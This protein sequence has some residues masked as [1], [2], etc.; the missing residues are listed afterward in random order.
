MGA[1]ATPRPYRP[2][3]AI[4]LRRYRSH[5]LRRPLTCA[6]PRWR[7]PA[8]PRAAA[9]RRSPTCAPL[10]QAPAQTRDGIVAGS[11]PAELVAL[12]QRLADAAPPSP[13]AICTGLTVD[14]K[15]DRAPSP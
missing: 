1:S 8:F 12:A 3:A 2:R 6:A 4:N 10:A 7:L 5:D 15:T 14:D 9:G 11:V 13:P